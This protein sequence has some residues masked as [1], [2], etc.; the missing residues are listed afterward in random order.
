MEHQQHE[1]PLDSRN[2][3]LEAAA[4]EVALVVVGLVVA[5]AAA[6][7]VAAVVAA[8]AAVVV[9]AAAEPF[10]QVPFE[11]RAVAVVEAAAFGAKSF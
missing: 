6:V 3:R 5:V 10:E 8:V 2:E 11:L 9:A 4:T 1:H 7:V